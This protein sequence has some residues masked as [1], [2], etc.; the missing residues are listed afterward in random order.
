[1]LASLA[2]QDALKNTSADSVCLQ[3]V[4]NQERLYAAVL[5]FQTPFKSSLPQEA[6]STEAISVNSVTCRC[7]RQCRVL[8]PP[9]RHTASTNRSHHCVVGIQSTVRVTAPPA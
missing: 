9:S 1:M 5:H 8:S 7:V 4:T 6:S 3:Q 2:K